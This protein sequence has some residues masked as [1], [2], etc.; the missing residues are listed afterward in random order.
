MN[1]ISSIGGTDDIGF[2]VIALNRPPEV[3]KFFIQPNFR[4]SGLGIVVARDVF[5]YIERVH[6]ETY[7]LQVLE[8]G[9][10]V[11]RAWSFWSKALKGRVA[12]QSRTNILIGAWD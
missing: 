1:F 7:S 9:A 5:S 12:R 2:C 3:A 6:S 11:D 8:Q 4:R 10:H